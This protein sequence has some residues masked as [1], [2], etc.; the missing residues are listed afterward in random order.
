MKE[1][2]RKLYDAFMK[3]NG[4]SPIVFTSRY[5]DVKEILAQYNNVSYI[6]DFPYELRNRNN[7]V[8]FA[9]RDNGMIV[10]LDIAGYI[11]HSDNPL[12]NKEAAEKEAVAILADRKLCPKPMRKYLIE[13][14][15]I[16][17]AMLNP[18]YGEQ[19]AKDL[20]QNN[21]NFLSQ[22]ILADS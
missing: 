18:V 13:N 4:N 15:L 20:V 3:K 16:P 5:S 14:K 17:D 21:M 12:Y 2:N 10:A 9:D 8:L 22:F 19:L 6:P 11:K 7:Y 1:H